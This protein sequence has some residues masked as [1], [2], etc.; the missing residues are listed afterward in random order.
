MAYR[1]KSVTPMPND[2]LVYDMYFGEQKTEAGIIVMDDDKKDRGIHPRWARVYA[3]GKKHEN[4]LKSGQWVLIEHGRWTRTFEFEAED[5]N[6]TFD[7]RR[8]DPK[9]ILLV[10][11]VDPEPQNHCMMGL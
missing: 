6:E 7:I 8:V 2:V 5:T 4:D 3:V 1:G 11:D 10:S 9:A